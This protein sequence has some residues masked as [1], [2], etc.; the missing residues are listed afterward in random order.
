[1]D[2]KKQ[3]KRAGIIL[4]L[5]MVLFQLGRQVFMEEE[6]EARNFVHDQVKSVFSDANDKVQA[7]YGIKPYAGGN[8]GQ[9]NLLSKPI[10][11][12]IHGLDEP[13]R[14]W[15]NLAPML[16]E[17]GYPVFLMSYPND[18]KVTASACLFFES[19]KKL[20]VNSGNRL[21]IIGHSMGGLVSR[22]M[23]TNPKIDYTAAANTGKVVR[24]SNLIMVGTPNHG[25][26]LARFRFFMEIRDQVQNLFEK[27]V[28][29]LQGLLDGTGAAGIDLI[30]GSRFLTVL[31]SRPHPKG[32]ALHV[33]AGVLSPWNSDDIQAVVRGFEAGL[34]GEN[35]QEIKGLENALIAINNTV[36]DGL[37]TLES[38]GLDNVPLTRV[39]GSHLTMIRNLTKDSMRI[40]P[41]IPVIMEI[42]EE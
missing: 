18:Q 26:Q 33:I 12:L 8:I 2:R 20:G 39:H 22:E 25:S 21:V 5:A 29:W 40:P 3:F 36:G 1:M 15:M 16:D 14:V 11:V 10:I 9:S 34:S 7:S 13:G 38:A 31:N 24:V 41:A 23:L 4:I 42:L 19:L 6:W 28:H 35:H 30:P 27:D 17:K 32:V 37:V